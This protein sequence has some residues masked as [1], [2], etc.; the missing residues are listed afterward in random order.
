MT[1]LSTEP[2]DTTVLQFVGSEFDTTASALKGIMIGNGASAVNRRVVG[3]FPANAADL[4][5]GSVYGRLF[6]Q[7]S[8]ITIKY[9]E[10]T[11]K[12]WLI[13][14]ITVEDKSGQ[15]LS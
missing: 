11:N 1:L 3:V 10:D 8:S 12:M 15:L 6:D 4:T 7:L 5:S 13:C 2:T 9:Y 14:A